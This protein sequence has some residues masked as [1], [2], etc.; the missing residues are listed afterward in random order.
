MTHPTAHARM[1]PHTS[2]RFTR[3]AL[4]ALAVAA[5][6]IACLV[7]SGCNGLG[8]VAKS[9]WNRLL[10]LPTETLYAATPQP[11]SYV[12]AYADAAG[13]GTN[14]VYRLTAADADGR[15]RTLEIIVFG[16]KASGDGYLKITAKG[17][18]G[19]RYDQVDE[20][21]VPGAALTALRAGA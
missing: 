12:D 5:A 20:T 14:Y 21:D 17:D 19:F 18:A 10:P 2:A 9:T 3:R 8:A 1:R 6:L 4:S 7:L 15:T 13:T 11:D 16:R